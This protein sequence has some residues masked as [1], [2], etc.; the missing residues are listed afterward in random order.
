MKFAKIVFWCA[1]IWGVLVLAPLY[2]MLHTVGL[3]NPPPVTH[4]EFYYGFVGVSLVWQFVF[5]LIATDPARFRPIMILSMLEKFVYVIT[6]IVL[7]MQ[8]RVNPDQ[9]WFVSTDLLLGLLFA[10]A[11]LKTPAMNELPA[12]VLP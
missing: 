11:F 12:T 4:P 1:G 5:C 3:R 7:Y 10:A 6:V 9:L 8:H 2:S